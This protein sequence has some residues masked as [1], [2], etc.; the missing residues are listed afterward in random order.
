[1]NN[2]LKKRPPIPRTDGRYSSASPDQSTSS[3]PTASTTSVGIET[4]LGGATPIEAE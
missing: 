3:P 4:L 1:L 2:L